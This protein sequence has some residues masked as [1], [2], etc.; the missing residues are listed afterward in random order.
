MYS[1]FFVIARVAFEESFIFWGYFKEK[2]RCTRLLN[3]DR[4]AYVCPPA[5]VLQRLGFEVGCEPK[6]Q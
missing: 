3:V 4:S 5:F 1:F 6:Q 2:Q